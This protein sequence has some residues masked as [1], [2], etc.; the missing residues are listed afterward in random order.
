MF[1]IP[2]AVDETIFARVKRTL[3]DSDTSSTNSKKIKII[4]SAWADN[5]RKGAR[6]FVWL[7]KNLDH[8]RYEFTF[9]GRLPKKYQGVSTTFYLASDQHQLNAITLCYKYKS[10][11]V[12]VQILFYVCLPHLL[13]LLSCRS[14][15]CSCSCT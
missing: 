2:N 6:T 14:C 10:V 1:V 13:H 3:P 4:A 9:I 15:S 8:E 11:S 7:D 5:E 12:C